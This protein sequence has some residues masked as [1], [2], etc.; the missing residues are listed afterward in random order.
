MNI[1]NFDVK[2][3]F[4]SVYKLLGPISAAI[5]HIE[6]QASTCSWVVILFMALVKDAG[7]WA[8]DTRVVQVLKAETIQEV[9]AKMKERWEGTEH[10][11]GAVKKVRC[12]YIR[13]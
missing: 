2:R 13:I 9:L 1:D 5:H 4:D 3:R 12:T 11:N 6:S 8:S 10:G 7:V